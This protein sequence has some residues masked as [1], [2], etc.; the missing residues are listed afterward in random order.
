MNELVV[1]KCFGHRQYVAFG[2]DGVTFKKKF[3]QKKICSFCFFVTE[4]EVGLHFKKFL[5]VFKVY[6]Q[7]FSSKCL[8]L[9][10]FE[11]LIRGT[12]ILYPVKLKSR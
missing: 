5:F 3:L 2:K 7:L 9:F 12:K 10:N 4:R 8:M 6:L 1:K 11:C